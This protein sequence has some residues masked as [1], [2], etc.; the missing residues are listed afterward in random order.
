MAATTNWG[1]EFGTPERAGPCR[2]DQGGRRPGVQVHIKGYRSKNGG[3]V[4]Y[5]VTLTLAD[6]RSL[7]DR[8]RAG[9]PGPER[10]RQQR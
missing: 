2:P 3:P 10:A 8:R 1:V 7:P 9:R 4:G 6:G 5:S